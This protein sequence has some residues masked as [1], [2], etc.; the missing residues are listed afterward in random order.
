MRATTINVLCSLTASLIIAVLMRTHTCLLKE[1]DA[2]DF[3]RHKPHAAW[4]PH[5]STEMAATDKFLAWLVSNPSFGT[6]AVSFAVFAIVPRMYGYK[7]EPSYMVH[8]AR[9]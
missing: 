7:L 1:L 2:H 9:R 8:D 3:A 6:D 4:L 5:I